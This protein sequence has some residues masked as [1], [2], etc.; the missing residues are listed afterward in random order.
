[1]DAGRAADR[2]FAGIPLPRRGSLVGGIN[3]R[4]TS[5]DALHQFAVSSP[6]E[7]VVAGDLAL[8]A[9]SGDARRP[10]LHVEGEA[11]TVGDLRDDVSRYVQAF[12]SLG[13]QPGTTVA[14]L[15]R[16]RPEVVTIILA[17]QI[18]GTVHFGLHPYAGVDDHAA[19]LADSGAELL[20]V[21]DVYAAHAEELRERVS[22]LRQVIAIGSSTVGED[23]RALAS[24]FVPGSL[25]RPPVDPE[26]PAVIGTTGGTTGRSKVVVM[27]HR[28][29]TRM[30]MIQMSEWDL[31]HE[32]RFLVCAP[33]SH[34]A[35]AFV[36]PT[37]LKGGSL[38]V[39][40][41]FAPQ[42]FLDAV[43]RYQINATMLVPTMIYSLLDHAGFDAADLSS[44]EIL[45][46]GASPISPHRLREGIKRIGPV[47]FQFYGQMEAPMAVT[48]LKREDHDPENLAR[49]AT[50]GRPVPWLR[51]ALLDDALEPV[52]L[53]E[54]GEICV[55]GPLV[56][57]EYR[58][59]A[60]ETEEA[61]RGGWLHTGDIARADADGFLTIA[62]RKKDMI[63]TGG[64]NV[65]PSEIEEVLA[66][67]PAVA[68][69]AV[70]GVPDPKWGEAVCA[71]VCVHDGAE[72]DADEL[73]ALVKERKGSVWAPK[74]VEFVDEI[75]LSG[76]GKVDK[77]ALR[78]PYWAAESRAVG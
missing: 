26:S 63:V 24:T 67:H 48:T 60:E 6:W 4:M 11:I 7:D 20:I 71:V 36:L 42:A 74:R 51:V 1:V 78:A 18:A 25:G 23:I 58:M 45:Y 27:P 2:I 16:N 56:M 61:L 30:T 21:D 31:P 39:L 62:D 34:S 8:R 13:L 44:L 41:S 29:W 40:P 68:Q 46:Y 72:V 73:R 35:Q 17:N 15:S 50:C 12:E 52:A 66:S 43:E 5:P 69:V 28:V 3:R 10:A 70:I 64:F 75:P 14:L 47:F 49:L 65:Y 76:L 22:T 54:P 19:V 53:G 55:R 37:L 57:R 38:V 77:K 32:P 33:L 9:L 59:R